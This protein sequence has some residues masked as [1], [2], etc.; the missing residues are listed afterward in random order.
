MATSTSA[1]SCA[2]LTAPPDGGQPSSTD[3]YGP[4]ASWLPGQ[5][6]TR[7]GDFSSCLAS[8]YSAG[9]PWSAM[10]P[11]TRTASTPVSPFTYAMTRAARSCRSGLPSRCRSLS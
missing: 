11:L 9:S 7:C 2:S 4:R 10:S 1:T 8:A 5:V 3:S 6:S